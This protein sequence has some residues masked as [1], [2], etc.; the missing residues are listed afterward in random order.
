MLGPGSNASR[1][2]FYEN[3]RNIEHFNFSAAELAG[4]VIPNKQV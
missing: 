4:H 1:V 3:P 2:N